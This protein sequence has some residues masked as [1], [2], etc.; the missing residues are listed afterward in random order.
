MKKIL[1]FQYQDASFEFYE[2]GSKLQELLISSLVQGDYKLIPD[3][4]YDPDWAFRVQKNENQLFVVLGYIKH[5]LHNWCISFE[6]LHYQQLD[7]VKLQEQ[8]NPIIHQAIN[9]LPNVSNITWYDNSDFL[10]LG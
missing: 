6:D 4:R 2:I 9:E 10:K 8:I 3:D 1:A 7:N 5:P